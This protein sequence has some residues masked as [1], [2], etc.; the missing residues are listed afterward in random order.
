MP[1]RT[2][3]QFIE[4]DVREF[5]RDLLAEVSKRGDF[6]G[7]QYEPYE[8]DEL[9]QEE[10]DNVERQVDQYRAELLTDLPRREAELEEEREGTFA[11]AAFEDIWL[12]QCLAPIDGDPST[13]VTKEA[14]EHY[15][16]WCEAVGIGQPYSLAKVRNALKSH[17]GIENIRTGLRAY[18][19]IDVPTKVNRN[20]VVSK[21][22]ADL[23]REEAE[24]RRQ[25]R[26]AA[27][28]Y[29]KLQD[30]TCPYCERRQYDGNRFD[31]CYWC[32][33][34]VRDGF[35]TALG[36]YLAD[37]PNRTGDSMRLAHRRM[38]AKG[39]LPEPQPAPPLP[40]RARPPGGQRQVAPPRAAQKKPGL[41]SAV[42]KAL[43]F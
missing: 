12:P 14:Y 7:M 13:L 34:I 38:I 4:D 3:K 20:Q 17:Y 35:E 27:K 2:A 24:L 11:I 10:K 6:R 22:E 31:R 33:R 40:S 8:I 42:L 5:R 41:I 32:N 21:Y 19:L 23:R 28:E 1:P 36:E 16:A 26:E 9:I 30:L 39:E 18:R 25:E 43:G 15:L 29:A 37:S